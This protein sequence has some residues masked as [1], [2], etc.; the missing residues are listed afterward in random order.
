MRTLKFLNVKV[1][2]MINNTKLFT[3]QSP[4]F[5]FETEQGLY[6]EPTDIIISQAEYISWA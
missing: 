2:I 5:D 4:C 6:T 1:I 3:V